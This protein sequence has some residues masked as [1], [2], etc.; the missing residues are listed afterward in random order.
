ML[1]TLFS[2]NLLDY[3]AMDI[4][5]AWEN[6]PKVIGSS[7]AVEIASKVKESLSVISSSLVDHEFRTTVFPG[8]HTVAD[9]LSI[10]GYLRDGEK[11]FIQDIRLEKTLGNL[12]ISD[13]LPAADL[14]KEVSLAFPLLRVSCR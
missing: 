12:T 14:L 8:V 2:Q 3:V 10:A 9:F 13:K 6:Y 7:H 5:A 1:K 4:K 11:Y